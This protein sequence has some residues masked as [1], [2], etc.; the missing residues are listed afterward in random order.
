MIA[1]FVHRDGQSVRM[2]DASALRD[3][4]WIDLQDPTDEECRQVEAATGLAVPSKAE[5]SEIEA[6]S[7]LQVRDGGLYLSLPIISM[8]DGP[9]GVSVGFVLT[10]DRLVSAR[11]APSL[12]F[13]GFSERVVGAKGGMTGTQVL[14]GLLEAIVDRQADVLEKVQSD[15]DAI[16]HRVFSLG[17]RTRSGRKI[18]D[19]RL[20]VTLVELGRLGDLISHIRDSQLGATR[21][22]PFVESNAADWLAHERRTLVPTPEAEHRYRQIEATREQLGDRITVTAMD[23]L[24]LKGFSE[25]VRAFKLIEV[26]TSANSAPAK[27]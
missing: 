3:A 16:S 8:A 4:F 10:Q 18:E 15:L 25:T 11:F 14:V 9:R 13:D 12:V 5:V 26:K 22:V 27:A 23:E 1:A 7:R 24:L 20:R 2:S 17:G 21:L 19:R 6:S